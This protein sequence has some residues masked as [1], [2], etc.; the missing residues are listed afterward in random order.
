MTDSILIYQPGQRVTDNDTGA[1]VEAGTLYFYTAGSAYATPLTVYSDSS[2]STTLGTFVALDSL[3]YPVSSGTAKTL[4]YTGA[5]S[6]AIVCKD[7]TGA[8]V[9]QHDGVR[10]A[11][12]TTTF[13]TSAVVPSKSVVATSSDRS[14]TS[15]DKGKLIDVNCT[16][17]TKTMT[18]ASASTLGDG[19]WCGIRHNGTANFVK[20]VGTLSQTFDISGATQTAFALITKGETVWITCDGSGFKVDGYVPPIA[21]GGT[22]VIQVA[23][24][25]SAP[26]ASPNAGA[27][28]IL[29]PAPTGA[30][31]TYAQND[32][33]RA[34]GQGAWQR[35]TIPANCGLR[36][37]VQSQSRDYQLQGSAWVAVGGASQADM[38]AMT[39]GPGATP[40][41][42]QWHP[43]VA[44]AFCKVTVS[45]GVPTINR[46]H[47]VASAV[48]ADS[49]VS[50]TITFTTAFSDA[51]YTA[52]ATVHGAA[53]RFVR[54]T[55][56]SAGSCVM[57]FNNNS[58]TG[59]A[60]DGFS[61]AFFG[62]Q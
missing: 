12:D 31:S 24:I 25:L 47:N 37:Y 7:A 29:G 61:V 45:G 4:I 9:W 20:I 26:P 53:P 56:Q 44:K 27:Y 5:T 54:M 62:D 3:G 59:A 22:G 17:A 18:F 50:I 38:E 57:T 16:G 15:A 41:N 40:A 51:N 21:L 23:D 42:M 30:W 33:V 8:T 52:A 49:G 43:G 58:T 1:P 34:D 35:Q 28:Y 10:G 46:S 19:F 48:T 39:S 13:L 32:L 11:L 14:I 55:S 36:S 6:Y 60:P 2:L